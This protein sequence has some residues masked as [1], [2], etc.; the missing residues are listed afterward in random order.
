MW[1][2][3]ARFEGDPGD[4]D[5]RVARLSE[6]LDG[7]LPAEFEGA[8]FLSLV[9][10][11]SGSMLGIV[12]FPSEEALRAGDAIMSAGSGHGGKRS[13]VDV[14]EVAIARI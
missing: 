14:Y 5:E 6:F 4:I 11:A 12:L 8:R 9:D 7:P 13:S 10:R 1:A 2:R 3:I